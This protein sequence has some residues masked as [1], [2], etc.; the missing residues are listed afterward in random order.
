VEFPLIECGEL[1]D[2]D[3]EVYGLI[4]ICPRCTAHA[5]LWFDV[6]FGV[7]SRPQNDRPTWER[8]G[9]SLETLSLQPSVNME[10][11]FHSW[12]LN[13]K[14]HVDSPFVCSRPQ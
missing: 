5:A 7:R 3:G 10:G 9:E 2:V 11:H 4:L 1:I 14:L 13:G 6:T 12:I 8:T